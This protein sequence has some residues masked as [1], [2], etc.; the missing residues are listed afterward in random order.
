LAEIRAWT[1]DL[2]GALDRQDGRIG[3]GDLA[4]LEAP[5]T[6]IFGTADPYLTPDLARHLAG[7]FRSGELHMLDGASHWPQWDQPEIVARLIEGASLEHT[8]KEAHR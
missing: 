6:L 2:P 4:A 3:A 8:M 7:L 5:V 1:A